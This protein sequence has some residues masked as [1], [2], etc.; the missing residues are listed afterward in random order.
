MTAIGVILGIFLALGVMIGIPY[1]SFSY[2]HTTLGL[3]IFE[4]IVIV[5][6]SYTI[7][8]SLIV[9]LQDKGQYRT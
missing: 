6:V 5:F 4:S 8:I 2:L 1:Y 3:G 9:Y 7:I